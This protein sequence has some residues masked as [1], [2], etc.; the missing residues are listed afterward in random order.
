M[1]GRYIGEGRVR[2]RKS[3]AGNQDTDL[4][5]EEKSNRR[6]LKLEKRKVRGTFGD[7]VFCCEVFCT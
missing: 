4:K 6:S 1:E 3:E 7:L 5:K 2:E